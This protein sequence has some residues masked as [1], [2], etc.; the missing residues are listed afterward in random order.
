MKLLFT[1]FAGL[2]M[3]V[4]VFAQTDL[5]V[6]GKVLDDAGSPMPGTNVLLKGTSVGVS[7][8]ANGDYSMNIPTGRADAVLMFSFIGYET[9]EVVVGTQSLI[10]VTLSADIHSLTEVVV[11]GYSEQ[12]KA[13]TTAAVSK[14]K[15]D[16][17][18]NT[19]NPNP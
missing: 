8:D 19:S 11:I 4:S 5:L 2:L 15:P 14:L 13:R 16:E 6:K 17:L 12:S 10:N 3:T 18:K 7:T 9:K 1:L